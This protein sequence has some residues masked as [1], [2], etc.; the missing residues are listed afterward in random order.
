MFQE[1]ML[2]LFPFDVQNLS[3]EVGT[4]WMGGAERLLVIIG[5]RPTGTPD[6]VLVLC[7]HNWIIYKIKDNVAGKGLMYNEVLLKVRQGIVSC[8]QWPR[9]RSAVRE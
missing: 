9:V 2:Q 5:H 1:L 7:I 6:P 3:I 8:I 4:G